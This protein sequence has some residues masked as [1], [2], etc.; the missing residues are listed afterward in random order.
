MY[1][2][3]SVVEQQLRA[4]FVL[5]PLFWPIGGVLLIESKKK[6]K[7]KKNDELD[8][9]GVWTHLQLEKTGSKELPG[10]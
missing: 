9:G 5:V 2:T 1:F 8:W 10:K 6:K 7:K 3:H 4:Y